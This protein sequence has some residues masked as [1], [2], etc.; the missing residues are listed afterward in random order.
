MLVLGLNPARV[1]DAL[2]A[3]EIFAVACHSSA[4]LRFLESIRMTILSTNWIRAYSC[5]RPLD[6]V[7]WR[8]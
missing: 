4:D 3:I 1:I 5:A 8:L 7:R 6:S 2:Y